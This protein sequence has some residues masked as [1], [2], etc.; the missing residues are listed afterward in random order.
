MMVSR[1][2]SAVVAALS[3]VLVL[4]GCSSSTGGAGSAGS[5][6]AGGGSSTPAPAGPGS[7]SA[8]AASVA[9]SSG[10]ST[11]GGSTSGGSTSG[12]STSG[13]SS[14]GAGAAI[15]VCTVLPPAAASQASGLTLTS[16]TASTPA[17]GQYFC[18]YSGTGISNPD[19]AVY[20]ADSGV[21]LAALKVALDGAASQDAPTVAVS[22]V[23]DKAYAG[24]DGVIA[25]FG[26][27]FIAVQGV[28]DDIFGKHATSEA[29]AKAVIAEL[30]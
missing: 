27:R 2:A 14:S 20:S 16:A 12:G 28:S 26:D 19:I 9:P 23:G 22:G 21:T 10:G 3:A 8:P 24:A 6:V 18:N 11:S 25:Q 1:S 15:D 17:Q 13:A 30:H 7:G 29:L 4:A 5:T